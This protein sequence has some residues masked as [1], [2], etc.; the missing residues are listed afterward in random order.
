MY[1]ESFTYRRLGRFCCFRFRKVYRSVK[2]KYVDQVNVDGSS[3]KHPNYVFSKRGFACMN[4]HVHLSH[5]IE[6]V[7][8]NVY[9]TQYNLNVYIYILTF[10]NCLDVSVLHILF[11]FFCYFGIIGTA[12]LDIMAAS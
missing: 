7:C 8:N 4:L 2:Y 1:D 6:S 9:V 10:G 3:P 5:T 11:Q 12:Y